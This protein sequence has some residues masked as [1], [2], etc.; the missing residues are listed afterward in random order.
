[1]SVWCVLNETGLGPSGR[2]AASD[3]RVEVPPR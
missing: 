1:M 3:L 2:D